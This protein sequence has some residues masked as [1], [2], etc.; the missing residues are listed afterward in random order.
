[1]CVGGAH[2]YNRIPRSEEDE[3]ARQGLQESECKCFCRESMSVRLSFHCPPLQHPTLLLAQ[4]LLDADAGKVGSELRTQVRIQTG[5]AETQGAA[6]ARWRDTVC[7]VPFTEAEQP[8]CSRSGSDSSI[9]DPFSKDSKYQIIHHKAT[10]QRSHL[11][12][13]AATLK[14][15][16]GVTSVGLKRLHE[17]LNK[18]RTLYLHSL[19]KEGVVM[20][21]LQH[22]CRQQQTP[23]TTPFC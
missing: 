21:Q 9:R 20:T 22:I 19:V 17:Q 3:R 23:P 11:L 8:L 18:A 14:R 5:S 16:P 4:L 7:S 2:P 6:E 13:A 12:S 15:R 1:M 10:D